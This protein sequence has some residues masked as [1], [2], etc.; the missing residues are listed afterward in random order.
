[1]LT[2]ITTLD[3]GE[4]RDVMGRYKDVED[5]LFKG[6][7][8]LTLE[9]GGV[10]LV[11][12]TLNQ[13]E[14]QIL[15]YMRSR[16][17]SWEVGASYFIAYSTL[18]FN[19]VNVL[20]RREEYVHLIAE[21]CVRWPTSVLISLLAATRRLNERSGE[22]LRVVQGYAYGPESRQLWQMYRGLPLC[23]VRVTGLEGT[24]NLG[25]NIHQRMWTYLNQLEDEEEKY[26][27]E[28][29]L[30]KFIVSPHAPKDVE[31]IDKQDRERMEER[32]RRKEALY[33]GREGEEEE[34]EA[35]QVLYVQKTA[36]DLMEQMRREQEGKQDFHDTV[37]AQHRERVRTA[38]LKRVAEQEKARRQAVEERIKDEV[39]EIYR[40]LSREGYSEDEILEHIQKTD[41]LARLRR[42]TRTHSYQGME[43][44]EMRL[45]RW[46]FITLEDIPQERRRAYMPED[47]N[48]L[49]K[50]EY[51][52][53]DMFGL[54]KPPVK[55]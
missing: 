40:E 1:M 39:S 42:Q 32:A 43:E 8:T 11:L 33:K 18:F 26:L 52:I 36:E 53:S 49:I 46:G 45:L 19:R 37:I 31:R 44:Q 23:D 41:A 48:P 2:L 13:T 30:A 35:G 10:P 25:L 47:E 5:L 22:A 20:T 34:G 50:D 14:F 27:Q 9:V 16:E 38:Y 17:D 21:Q 24:S 4:V 7:L 55:P 29:A 15:E 54:E 51:D 12:K 6:F 3:K 28:Y